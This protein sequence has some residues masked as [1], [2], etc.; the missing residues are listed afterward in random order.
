MKKNNKTITNPDE[1]NKNLQYSSPITWI[2]LTSVV[3]LLLGFFVW[4]CIYSI[5]LKLT[6]M[7]SINEGQVTLV[8]EARSINK[9]QV[10]QKVYIAGQEGEILSIKDDQP[11][12]STFSLKDGDYEYYIVIGEKKPVEFL[13]GK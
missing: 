11:V 13:L 5:T 2:I 1:L 8:I 4:S 12:V 6:G 7:A 10:G 9:L 3:F